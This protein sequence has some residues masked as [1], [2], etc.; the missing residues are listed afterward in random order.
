MRWGVADAKY[1][2]PVVW[3]GPGTTESNPL[4]CCAVPHHHHLPALPLCRLP[5]PPSLC[6]CVCSHV[7]IS[8]YPVIVYAMNFNNLLDC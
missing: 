7:G 8:L 5:I 4:L 3:R 1:R 2:S 6:V